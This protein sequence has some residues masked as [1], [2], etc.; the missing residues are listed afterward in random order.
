[1][2][3]VASEAASL[4]GHL[5]LGNLIAVSSHLTYCTAKVALMTTSRSTMTTVSHRPGIVANRQCRAN[6]SLLDI[7]ID[8]DT[9]VAF[10]EDVEKRFQAYGWQ[11]LH[12]DNGDRYESW[13]EHPGRVFMSSTAI[14]RASTTPSLRRARRRTSLPS[15]AFAP[16]SVTVQSSRARTVSTVPVCPAIHRADL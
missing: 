4:A 14:S 3:G 2:E 10:T 6:R 11:T 15:S 13:R 5:Q 12:V 8:G 16:P 9:A 7:S 1:M